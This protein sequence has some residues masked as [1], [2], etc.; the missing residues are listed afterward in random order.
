MS[1]SR[2][3][4]QNGLGNKKIKYFWH[5]VVVKA[6]TEIIFW[7]SGARIFSPMPELYITDPINKFPPKILFG[8]ALSI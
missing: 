3:S 2:G 1:T 6:N 8:L 7:V 5:Q 4:P